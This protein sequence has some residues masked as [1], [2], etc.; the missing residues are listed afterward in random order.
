M[1]QALALF[2]RSHADTVLSPVILGLESCYVQK[3]E[4]RLPD[5]SEYKS[6]RRGYALL[7]TFTCPEPSRGCNIGSSNAD[8]T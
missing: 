8:I 7:R 2:L 5:I 4:G 6:S 3:L 1:I